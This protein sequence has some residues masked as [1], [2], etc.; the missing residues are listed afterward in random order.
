MEFASLNPPWQAIPSNK[1]LNGF[2]NARHF[3]SSLRR[4][5]RPTLPWL[6]RLLQHRRQ[7]FSGVAARRLDD[8]F[9]RTPGDDFAAVLGA[10][11]ITQ[12]LAT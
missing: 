6:A 2:Q 8:V 12:V 10:K 4:F 7:E 5:A 1:S 11:S 3:E 9:R